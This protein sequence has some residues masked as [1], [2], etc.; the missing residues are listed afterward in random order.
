MV[1]AKNEIKA[2]H[3]RMLARR[4]KKHTVRQQRFTEPSLERPPGLFYP[5]KRYRL[6]FGSPDLPRNR[7]L[8]HKKAVVDGVKGVLVP[9]DDGE[10]PW[11]INNR[12]GN[13]LEKDDEESISDS[14][15]SLADKKFNELDQDRKRKY[16]EVPP[17]LTGTSH[18]RR[19]SSH[20]RTGSHHR[21]SSLPSC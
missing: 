5:M 3:K 1:R 2:P 19:L 15:E 7:V 13:R 14:D 18:C 21:R 16:A 12:S 8:K 11:K 20:R 17:T 4:G 9:G 10:Q 6:K